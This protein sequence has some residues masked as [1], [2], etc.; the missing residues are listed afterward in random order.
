MDARAILKKLQ[1]NKEFMDVC[2]FKRK[3][4]KRVDITIFTDYEGE[5]FD[6]WLRVELHMVDEL[7]VKIDTVLKS[8]KE[9]LETPKPKVVEKKYNI[10][11]EIFSFMPKEF[12]ITE[13]PEKPAI[14]EN[15]RKASN[16]A[17]WDKNKEKINE[18]RRLNY[19]PRIR[20]EAK[21]D[22]KAY[23][24]EAYQK[25]KKALQEKALKRYH[26]KKKAKKDN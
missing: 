24:K 14:N 6:V 3:K 10:R 16:G 20:A 8:R 9:L 25:N 18:N 2:D 11:D 23:N 17:Y 19:E 26:E 4:S 22:K 21:F 7:P 5:K 13:K 1:E 12:R 15:K